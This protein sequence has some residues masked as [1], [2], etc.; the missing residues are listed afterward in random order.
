MV[1]EQDLLYGDNKLSVQNQKE[2]SKITKYYKKQAKQ[3]GKEF[4][5][6]IS[7]IPKQNIAKM[8]EE[9]IRKNKIFTKLIPILKE[10]GFE[11]I[12]YT[13]TMCESEIH[14][15]TLRMQIPTGNGKDINECVIDFWQNEYDLYISANLLLCT[16]NIKYI[17]TVLQ[18]L[19]RL[20]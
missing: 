7:Q 14:T 19:L 11:N 5:Q 8:I 13:Y 3:F 12:D 10:F 6:A 2:L 17:K 4:S 15:H 1:T 18:G 20:K 9:R 16:D